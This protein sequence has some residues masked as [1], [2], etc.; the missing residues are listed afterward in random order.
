MKQKHEFEEAVET[1]ETLKKS[2]IYTEIL[3]RQDEGSMFRCNEKDE[4]GIVPSGFFEKIFE[5]YKAN[6]LIEVYNEEI[7]RPIVEAIR[8]I[9]KE[10][11]KRYDGETISE[12][13]ELA[14]FITGDDKLYCY[15]ESLL[16]AGLWCLNAKE[17]AKT[18]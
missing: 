11:F 1:F 14:L 9:E 16:L 15:G 8:A 12:E 6:V 13:E 2:G 4:I 17:M 10:G 5:T 7:K 3:I 18:A